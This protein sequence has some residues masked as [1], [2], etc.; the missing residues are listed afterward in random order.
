M[1]RKNQQALL[2]Q[3]WVKLSEELAHVNTRGRRHEP[4]GS[5]A[6]KWLQC[7]LHSLISSHEL[8]QCPCYGTY[9]TNSS[10]WVSI[11]IV[12]GE[13]ETLK[14]EYLKKLLH[15]KKK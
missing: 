12:W 15:G 4:T 14:F 13:I 5:T 2:Q 11:Q 7:S 9:D 10:S 6:E 1:A 8:L 3:W